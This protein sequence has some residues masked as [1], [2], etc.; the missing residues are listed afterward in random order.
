MV[1]KGGRQWK[2]NILQLDL[3]EENN[4]KIKMKKAF[5]DIFENVQLIQE[6]RVRNLLNKDEKKFHRHQRKKLTK[7]KLL[8][9]MHIQK[10]IFFI[11]IVFQK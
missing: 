8:E 10:Q 7:G 5:F 6:F 4:S 3:V 9:I 1:I 11:V 2:I